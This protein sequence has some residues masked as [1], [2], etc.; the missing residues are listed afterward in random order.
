MGY[1]PFYNSVPE[2]IS[3]TCATFATFA[4]VQDRNQ[5]NV[6]N[7]AIVAS[8]IPETESRS[9]PETATEPLP[10]AKQTVQPGLSPEDQIIAFEERAAILEYDDGLP[11]KEAERLAR[12][13]VRHRATPTQD[14]RD[15][16]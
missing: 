12:V 16:R 10:I 11:R 3:A 15:A 14:E 9:V 7:V 13:Q 5:P 6:A 2:T 4:T 8:P 1:R